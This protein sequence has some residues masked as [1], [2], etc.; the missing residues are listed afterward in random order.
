MT[1]GSRQ[2]WL[3]LLLLG[4]ALALGLVISAA[5]GAAALTR[6]KLSH[7]TIEVKGYA[8][9]LV[10]SD[11]AVWTGTFSVR[12]PALADGYRTLSDQR[13]RVLAFLVSLGLAAKDVAMDPVDVVAEHPRDK[14]GNE[15]DEVTGYRL[16]QGLSVS[17]GDV[18]LVDRVSRGSSALLAEGIGFESRAPE[19]YCTTLDDL[20]LAMLGQATKNARQ[21]AEKLASGSGG[22]IGALASASQGVFQI[23]P[24][25]ST[26]VSGSGI[27]D[28]T[29][30]EK[31]VK[32]VVTVEYSLR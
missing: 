10:T 29:T 32:A 11:W 12:A 13:E 9:K 16:T 22:R 21:R 19:Y 18:S 20:K 8:E 31:A 26:E 25:R 17:T 7:Q 1:N 14:D 28:T 15:T 6:I 23:T 30:I 5:I 2:Q 4:A 3:G 27:Y 24:V